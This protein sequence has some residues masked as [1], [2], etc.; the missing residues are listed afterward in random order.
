M[1]ASAN[2]SIGIQTDMLGNIAKKIFG[3]KNDRELKRMG[4]LV[5]QV[6]ALEDDIKNLS[7]DDLKAKT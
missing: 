5:V 2:A 6:N 1:R 7:D 4:K 3:S